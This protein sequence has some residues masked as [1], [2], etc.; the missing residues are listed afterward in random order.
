MQKLIVILICVTGVFAFGL[1]LHAF[2]VQPVLRGILN[3]VF[4]FL[5]GYFVVAPFFRKKDTN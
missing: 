5:T 2:D 4:G 1:M 3:A